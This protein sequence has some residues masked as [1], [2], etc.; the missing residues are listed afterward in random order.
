MILTLFCVS[1]GTY[2]TE[3]G[4]TA[5]MKACKVGNDSNCE[6][7]WDVYVM[8][9]HGYNTFYL[10][11]PFEGCGRYCTGIFCNSTDGIRFII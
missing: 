8:H 6:Q 3:Y 4:E 10:K 11:S 5:V 2:P 7:S 9:C 1:V